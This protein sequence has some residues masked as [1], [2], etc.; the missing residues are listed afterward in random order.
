MK[1]L[2]EQVL[3]PTDATWADQLIDSL[4]GD[5]T[6]KLG[7]EGVLLF[8]SAPAVAPYHYSLLLRPYNFAYWGVFNA[9]KFP[10]AQVPLGLNSDGLPVGIQVV[11][12]PENDALALA[13]AEH[14][15]KLFGG[16]VPP[17]KVLD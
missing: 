6:S 1:L 8:P 10:A 2:D 9:I 5:L 15:G 7:S 13:V 16:F 11:A 17:C 12:A 4:T 14:L 3:P